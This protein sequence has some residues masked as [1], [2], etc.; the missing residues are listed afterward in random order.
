M[1]L[2]RDDVRKVALLARLQIQD[3]QLDT[4]TQHL[5]RVIDYVQQLAQLDTSHVI[6]LAH[7]L[8]LANVLADDEPAE[9]LAQSEAL[10]NAPKQDGQCYLVPAVLGE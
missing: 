6:P 9:G 10:R 2:S 1:S 4:M 8:D 5:S 3:E 7:P